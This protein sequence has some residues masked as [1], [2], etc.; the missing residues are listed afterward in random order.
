MFSLCVS[1][2]NMSLVYDMEDVNCLKIMYMEVAVLLRRAA[3]LHFVKVSRLLVYSEWGGGGRE[4]GFWV[5]G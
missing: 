4:G 1:N 5:T 2:I 3:D